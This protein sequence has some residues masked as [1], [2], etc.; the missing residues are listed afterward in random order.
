MCQA[1]SPQKQE[2]LLEPRSVLANNKNS[3][4]LGGTQQVN[5]SAIHVTETRMVDEVLG[6]GK[7][8]ASQG[9]LS[10]KP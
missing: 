8:T 2:N 5:C 7:L 1:P 4:W 10:L 9:C 6:R 3:T